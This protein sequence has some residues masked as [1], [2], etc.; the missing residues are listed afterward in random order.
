MTN[1]NYDK[2]PS[3]M[4]EAAVAE[5]KPGRERE[6]HERLAF[7]ALR[8]Q[9]ARRRWGIFFKLTMLSFLIVAVWAAFDL[10]GAEEAG[11]THTALIEFD[12]TIEAG[13]VSGSTDTVIPA[14]DRA[15]SVG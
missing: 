7:E 12:G 8:E 13:G 4:Q 2:Q 6:V 15:F 11:G 9:R 14:L 3:I 5:K 1:E 10:S